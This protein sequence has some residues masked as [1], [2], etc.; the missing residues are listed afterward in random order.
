MKYVNK[1]KDTNK[2]T[3]NECNEYDF[4]ISRFDV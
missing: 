1:S 3:E 4:D 2:Q